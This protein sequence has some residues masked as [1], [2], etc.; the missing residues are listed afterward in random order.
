MKNG[1]LGWGLTAATVIAWDL[2]AEETM[3]CAFSRSIRRKSTRPFV[4]GI[5]AILTL[6]L[7]SVLP[8][9]VDPFKIFVKAAKRT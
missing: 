6:H 7:F 8:E 3:S 1:A 5:W 4:A 9:K 2:T